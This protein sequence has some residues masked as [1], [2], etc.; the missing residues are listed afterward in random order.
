M[1]VSCG[2]GRDHAPTGT[3]DDY[4]DGGDGDGIIATC[5]GDD[6][7]LG[8]DGFNMLSAGEGEDTVHGFMY[9]VGAEDPPFCY[10]DAD[11]IDGEVR[12]PLRC[13]SSLRGLRV[14]GLNSR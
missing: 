1:S 14:P 11:T 8:G 5:A 10:Q 13:P 7:L 9:F 6:F 3:N 4:V 12:V 2:M